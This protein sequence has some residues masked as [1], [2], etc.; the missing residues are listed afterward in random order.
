QGNDALHTRHAEGGGGIDGGEA[1]AVNGCRLHRSIE[2]AGEL[3]VDTVA[4]RALDL[5]GDVE[6]LGRGADDLEVLAGLE[7]RAGGHAEAGSLCGQLAVAG[8]ASA[9]GVRDDAGGR[10]ELLR[11]EIPAAGGCLDQ[12]GAGG[13]AD[14]AHADLAG[15]AHGG[16]AAGDL[17]SEEAGGL[18]EGHVDGAVQE[19]RH[20]EVLQHPAF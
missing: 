1:A 8:A 4:G 7:G 19:G 12:H 15:E 6:A 9:G 5:R 3:N 20:A 13:G 17:Q 11:G 10:G 14:D 2:H 16:G 18:R